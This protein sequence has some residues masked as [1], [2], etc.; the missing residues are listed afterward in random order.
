MYGFRV[1]PDSRELKIRCNACIFYVNQLLSRQDN[2]Q[3]AHVIA[4][5][6]KMSLLLLKYTC[7]RIKAN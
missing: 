2:P 7:T 1:E 6:Q 3:A 4:M 5:R